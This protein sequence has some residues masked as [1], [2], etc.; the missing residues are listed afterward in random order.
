MKKTGKVVL[1]LLFGAAM[2]VCGIFVPSYFL[3]MDYMKEPV[4]LEKAPADPTEIEATATPEAPDLGKVKILSF[5]C[6]PDPDLLGTSHVV[7]EVRNQ[8]STTVQWVKI[9]TT[10]YDTQG[11]MTHTDFTYCMPKTL[12]PGQSCTFDSWMDS[13]SESIKCG[14]RVTYK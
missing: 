9:I 10:F 12:K 2:F 14:V 3:A 6:Y 11:D 7:G 4:N 5:R 1:I 8:G 13:N